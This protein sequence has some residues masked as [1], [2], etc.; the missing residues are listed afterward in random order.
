MRRERRKDFRVDYRRGAPI[1]AN[2][3]GSPV[4]V[5]GTRST[6]NLRRRWWWWRGRKL[7]GWPRTRFWDLAAPGWLGIPET[8]GLKS[9][10]WATHQFSRRL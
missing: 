7:S 1:P 8:P 6:V 3:I 4:G 5:P 9:E 10:T 2:R